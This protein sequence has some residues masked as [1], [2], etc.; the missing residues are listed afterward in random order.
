MEEMIEM[1]NK[2]KDSADI[3]QPDEA[4]G[5]SQREVQLSILQVSILDDNEP[6]QRNSVGSI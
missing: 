1:Q 3:D 4:E 2:G 6:S 5:G